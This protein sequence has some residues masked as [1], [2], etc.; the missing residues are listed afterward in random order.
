VKRQALDSSVLAS[1]GYDAERRILEL[2]F[3]DGDVYRYWIVPAHVWREL[4]EAESAG[5]Y[6]AT[7]IR[8]RYPTEKL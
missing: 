5:H 8:D 2:E 7:E 1:A 4:L 6:F 3:V